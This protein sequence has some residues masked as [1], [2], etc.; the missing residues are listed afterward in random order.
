MRHLTA[1]VLVLVFTQA[2]TACSPLPWV[3]WHM[4]VQVEALLAKPSVAFRSV[5]VHGHPDIGDLLPASKA[6]FRSKEEWKSFVAQ[7]VIR[8]DPFEALDFAQETG[9]LVAYGESLGTNFVE[10]VAIEEQGD[11]LFVH[12][13]RWVPDPAVPERQGIG[14]PYHF[15]TIPKTERPIE[16]APIQDAY[17]TLRPTSKPSPKVELPT[18]RAS[19]SAVPAEMAVRLE[20]ARAAGT[21]EFETLWTSRTRYIFGLDATNKVFTS[22]SD[23]AI[24]FDRPEDLPVVDFDR[25]AVVLAA[26]G[27]QHTGMIEGEIVGIEEQDDQLVVHSVLWM[28]PPMSGVTADIGWPYHLVAVPKRDKP[29][30]FEPAIEVDWRLRPSPGI[31]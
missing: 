26:F 29:I 18:P 23:M 3:E 9:I 16:F 17:I 11:R 19:D 25:F 8:P 10:I 30:V 4:G 20:K 22:Q 2:G 7:T 27:Q 21:V 14:Y 1:I 31:R 24:F 28:P 6:V 13:V 12:S 15:V 5:G